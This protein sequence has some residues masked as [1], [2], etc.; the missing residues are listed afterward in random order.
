MLVSA[1]VLPERFGRYQ[2]LQVLGQGSMGFVFDVQDTEAFR[3]V[4]LKVPINKP[5]NTTAMRQR[6]NAFF[7]REMQ[8]YAQIY[9]PNLCPVLEL[10][11]VGGV[12]YVTMPLVEGTPLAQRLGSAPPWP[13]RE[14]VEFIKKIALTVQVLHES[15]LVHRDI[16]PACILERYGHE[17]L[18][19]DYC[20]IDPLNGSTTTLTG[21]KQNSAYMSPE[22]LLGVPQNIGPASDI[23]NLGAI[24]YHL[25]SGRMPFLD[26]PGLIFDHIRHTEPA[27][28][29]MLRSGLDPVLANLCMKAMRKK[30]E[31]RHHSV[32]AFLEGLDEFLDREPVTRGFLDPAANRE[33]DA[34]LKVAITQAEEEKQ[35]RR[36]VEEQRDN[37]LGQLRQLR[38]RL[39]QALTAEKSYRAMEVQMQL[40]V[41][42][43]AEREQQYRRQA[44]EERDQLLADMT[45][46]RIQL[47]EAGKLGPRVAELE[48]HLEQINLEKAKAVE[49]VAQRSTE[50][51]LRLH[52]YDLRRRTA[53]EQLTGLQEAKAALEQERDL[54]LAELDQ[55]KQLLQDYAVR[56]ER[57]EF[58]V[59]EAE[60]AAQKPATPVMLAEDT[61]PMEVEVLARLRSVEDELDA[62]R[63]AREN[64]Q[65]EREQLVTELHRL[66][67][68][69][70]QAPAAVDNQT[71][72]PDPEKARL[73]AEV[74]RL[75]DEVDRLRL[76]E[77][78]FDRMDQ[79]RLTAEAERDRIITA[80]EHVRSDTQGSA[81]ADHRLQQLQQLLAQEQEARL[82]AEHRMRKLL[83]QYDQ[84]TEKVRKFESQPA[85]SLPSPTSVHLLTP[86]AVNGPI[87]IAVA[88]TF[89][90]RP[91]KQPQA[92]W[93]QIAETPAVVQDQPGSVYWLTLDGRINNADLAGLAKFNGL[94]TLQQLMFWYCGRIT[95]EGLE[96][97]KTLPHL[98]QLMFWSCGRITDAG[99]AHLATLTDLQQ[100]MFM[101]CG[102]I[103]GRCFEYLTGLKK[104]HT[105]ALKQAGPITDDDLARLAKLTNLQVL[106]LGDCS[107]VT[108]FGLMHLH[109]LTRLQRLNLGGH[110]MVSEAATEG[111]C[112]AAPDCVISR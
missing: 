19:L 4:A 46:L 25:L 75:R 45:Q 98:Q 28:P 68:E 70:S 93:L 77:E 64:L 40:Q 24:L 13:P 9:H 107:K 111:L 73:A 42:S 43:L 5:K 29:A 50:E 11:E 69:A 3:R 2:V 92:E 83:V 62:E 15:G 23:Y 89:Y 91:A 66:R 63:Q 10:G 6:D 32:A 53:E 14:A 59:A 72:Q 81:E 79:A 27:S 94:P 95:D 7:K 47:E 58:L 39:E 17:P 90:A 52:D 100:L 20:F 1:S 34:K 57:L 51:M 74:D 49:K 60:S 33:M 21:N 80:A 109:S 26:M 61:M 101:N 67:E 38:E 87:E 22:S 84:L 99:V 82:S 44:L 97:L 71:D 8:V 54:A 36:Q 96:E 103:S 35:A 12:P 112:R 37:A 31:E 86:Q 102:R 108:D 55:A 104:L 56:Q 30:P 76:L 85:S 105:L 48:A 78:Q 18:L 41:E 110:P 16:K 106:D 88:G 65:T